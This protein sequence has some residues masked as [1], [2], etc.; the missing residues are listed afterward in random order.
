MVRTGRRRRLFL[1]RAIY[2]LILLAVLLCVYCSWF[3]DRRLTFWEMM[4]GVSLHTRDLAEFAGSFFYVFMAVQF[5]MVVWLTPAYTAGAIAVEKEQ[6]TLD[7]LLAT[8]LRSREIVLST[9]VSRLANLVMLILAGLPIL[10]L[11]QFM[12]GVDP[13]MVLAGFAAVGLTAISLAALGTVNSLYAKKPRDAVMRTYMAAAGYLI[14]SGLSWLLLLPQLSLTTF[15]STEDWTSPVELQDVVESGSIGNILAVIG[16]LIHAIN[17]G[18]RLDL[19][20]PP[21]LEKYVWFHGLVAIGCGV[22]TVARFRNKVLEPRESIPKTSRKKPSRVG[23]WRSWSGRPP[24]SKRA[25][26]WKELFVGVGRRDRLLGRLASGVFF[27]VV[28]LPAIHMIHFFGRVWPL[29]AEDSMLGMMNYWVRAASAF[30]GCTMLLEVAVRAASCLS[31]ERDRQTLDGLLATPLDNRTILWEK[32]LGCVLTQRFT[33]LTLVLVWIV[34]ILTGS[35]HWLAVPCFVVA[36]LGY[37]GFVAGLGLWF[38]VANRSTLRSVFG[39]LCALVLMFLVLLLAAFDIP[40]SWLPPWLHHLWAFILLPPATLALLSFS[41][42]D[43]QNWLTGKLELQYVPL[44]L[45]LQFLLCWLAAFGMVILANIRFRVVT[46]RTSGLPNPPCSLPEASAPLRPLT[47]PPLPH[48]GEGGVRGRVAAK[49]LPTL[50]APFSR[51]AQRSAGASLLLST[52]SMTENEEPST[53]EEISGPSRS[54]R[55]VGW[56]L[57]LSPVIM[58]LGWY[59]YSHL[60]AEKSLEEMV[61]SLNRSDPGWRL[62][63]IEAARAV[64]PDEENSARVIREVKIHFP[65]DWDVGRG[66][67]FYELF[68]DLAPEKQLNDKQVQELTEYFERLEPFLI[69]AR[70]LI[71]MPRGRAPIHWTNDGIS[72]LL[73]ETQNTRTGAT[74]LEYDA[75]LRSQENDPDGALDSCR[76]ILNSGRSI[77]D[78]PTLISTLVRIAIEGV[79]V[80]SLERSLAQ[81]QPGEDAMRKL[82]SLLEDEE[83]APLMLTGMRGERAV[84]DRLLASLQSGKISLKKLRGLW[85]GGEE[86]ILVAGSIK[87]QRAIFLEIMTENVEASKLPVEQQEAEFKRIDKTIVHRP[88]LIRMLMPAGMKVDQAFLRSRAY[89]RTAIV[90]LAVERYRREHGRWPATLTELVPSKL[91]NIPVDPYDGQPLR[92]RRNTDGVVIYSVGPDKTDDG[93]KLD[94]KNWMAPSTDLGIQ[95]WDPAKRRQPPPPPKTPGQEEENDK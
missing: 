16:Q 55:L 78:E 49:P 94:R 13:N 91:A 68:Q 29:N 70:R 18:G 7:A 34:G 64:V 61:A 63:E 71:D 47:P 89:L 50:T 19:L 60:A 36:W 82:Q 66:Q 5:L 1:I 28:F 65:G 4:R 75:I 37:A 10:A 67:K 25:I 20:L 92:Y 31:G 79:A 81:G 45:A 22:L 74:F 58:A 41:P 17:K 9:Y 62:E 40:E 54:R 83:K 59:G 44:L 26:L 76:G 35:L 90:A 95:L 2:S 85:G 72:T 56:L 30:I 43:L 51:D 15:P 24:V 53:H 12:G 77:G 87:S 52:D 21:M 84:F 48:G 11:L 93:G 73:T 80:A 46:G 88:L 8:D 86:M 57:F 27:A 32:W 14:L 23:S 3:L 42:A 6:Q 33:A 69:V 38:S 39:T